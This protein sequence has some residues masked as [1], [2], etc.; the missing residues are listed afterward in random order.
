MPNLNSGY[1]NNINAVTVRAEGTISHV[2]TD[3]NIDFNGDGVKEQQTS[4][5]TPTGVGQNI[6]YV[7][8][9]P[10]GAKHTIIHSA[11][12]TDGGV[13][14]RTGQFTTGV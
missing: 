1:K 6:T 2:Y 4:V 7:V 8:T 12:E 3:R 5:G 9:N 11:T 10:A 14:K 13:A